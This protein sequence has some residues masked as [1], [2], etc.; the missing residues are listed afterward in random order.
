MSK[1]A[2]NAKNTPAKNV[3]PVTAAAKRLSE[4]FK[5]VDAKALQ[6][7]YDNTQAGAGRPW[8]PPPGDYIL[9][10]LAGAEVRVC[11]SKGAKTKGQ[12]YLRLD[13]PFEIVSADVGSEELIGKSFKISLSL[14]Q[15]SNQDGETSII[16]GGTIK[17]L[18]EQAFGSEIPDIKA[19]CLKLTE[20]LEG[21]EF[22]VAIKE[23]KKN[24]QYNRY[25]FNGLVDQGEGEEADEEEDH[26]DNDE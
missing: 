24:S 12:K 15:V 26:G 14:M 10:A 20:E 6:G 3:A 1:N 17:A 23:D 4:A 19:A 11:E 9:K 8:S 7:G 18:C 5:V 13:L 22:D 21:F 16:D 2:K 25:Y